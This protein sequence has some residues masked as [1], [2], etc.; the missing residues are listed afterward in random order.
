[1]PECG[2]IGAQDLRQSRDA[3]AGD[4]LLPDQFIFCRG[5]ILFS[6]VVIHPSHNDLPS[7]LPSSMA[8]I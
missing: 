5:E 1:V 4:G 2:L 3:D 7:G 8:M 6:M